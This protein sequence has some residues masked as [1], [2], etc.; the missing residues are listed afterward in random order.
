MLL[1]GIS[2]GLFNVT[3]SS[4]LQVR[5]RDD[6][7]GRIMAVYS[8]GILGSALIGA[9]LAGATADAFG[10]PRTL[11]IIAVICAATS[12]ITWWIALTQARSGG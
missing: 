6:L 1:L 8:I 10:V 4:I 9:P 12:A 3:V 2:Y 11:L 5:A 7:R